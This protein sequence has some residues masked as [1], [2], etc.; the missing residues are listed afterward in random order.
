[1]NKDAIFYPVYLCKLCNKKVINTDLAESIDSD[2]MEKGLKN[3]HSFSTL[4]EENTLLHNHIDKTNCYGLCSIL[5][6]MEGNNY[7]RY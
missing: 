6:F 1:M 7:G 5:G 3:L 2:D 4:F